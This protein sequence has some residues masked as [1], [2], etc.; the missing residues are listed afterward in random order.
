MTKATAKPNQTEAAPRAV[1]VSQAPLAAVIDIG[2]TA[3]RMEI[4]EM[5]A[6]AEARPIESL[7]R[8]VQLGKDAFTKGRIEQATIQECVDILKD[9]KRVMA[10][11]GITESEQVRAVATSPIREAANRDTFL[12]RVYIATGINVR[13]ID[14]AEESRL[15]YLAAR[16]VTEAD[17]ALREGDVLVVDVGG[18][19][20]EV[21]LICKGYVTFANSYRLGSL[22]M[23][24]TLETYRT[25]VERIRAILGP[26]IQRMVEQIT[27]N[28]PAAKLAAMV[29]MS[30]D[31]RF[32]AAQLAPKWKEEPLARLDAKAFAGFVDK[33]LP[34]SVDK[35]VSRYQVTY[36]EAETV[37]PALLAYVHLARAFK[38]EQ[39]LVPKT[40]LRDGLLRDIALGGSWTDAFAGQVIHSAVALG[41]KYHADPGHAR[42]VA[43]LCLKL[44]DALREEHRLAPRHRVLLEVA[45]L[46]HEVGGFISSRSHHKHSMYLILNSELF[47]LSRE[48]TQLVALTARYHRRALPAP[49]HE[50]YMQL[51]RE[52]RIIVSKMAAILR[53]A[54][55]LDRN[56]NQQVRDMA[57][58]R[59][60][61]RLT[62]TVRNVE[63]LTLERMA[64]KEK[65]NLFEEIYGLPVALQESRADMGAPD[66]A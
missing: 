58:V 25:P 41:E 10:E 53:L 61:D 26:S 55:A 57:I 23:R 63:D 42:Q 19:S 28:V 1:P 40:S 16:S 22:R 50:E 20:T 60:P 4:A 13:A 35:I 62:I 18:G 17:P 31:T 48:D 45:A 56:H 34:L 32:A 39:V 54:D 8:G 64:V 7:R 47:G 27:R 36:P 2:A 5:I 52:R 30:G 44:F 43:D 12:D 21:L 15:T 24:E 11:Y 66:H 9:F 51:D 49:T 59:E 6:G 33:V 29:A 14:E 65:G 3:I 37:G 38:V 46:L